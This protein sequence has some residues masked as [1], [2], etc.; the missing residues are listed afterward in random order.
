MK[1]RWYD[2]N[3]S[4]SMAVS[5]LRNASRTHQE[6]AARYILRLLEKEHLL[7]RPES[8]PLGALQHMFPRI[9]NRSGFEPTSRRLLEVLK[10]LPPE[11][12]QEMAVTL[13]NYIYMLDCDAADDLRET[14]R[15]MTS[16][17]SAMTEPAIND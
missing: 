17:E 5:L 7:N 2:S 3:A 4:L 9:L 11:R 8:P 15:E 10:T 1:N 6:M 12:Q 16:P 13:I 14:L